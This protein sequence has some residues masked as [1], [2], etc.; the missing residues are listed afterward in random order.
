[1]HIWHAFPGLVR[2][3]FPQTKC[4]P[5]FRRQKCTLI[6]KYLSASCTFFFPQRVLLFFQK[7]II[8]LMFQSLLLTITY[9][10]TSMYH[11]KFS[12]NL[13]DHILPYVQKAKK[14]NR[15]LWLLRMPL[16]DVWFSAINGLYIWFCPW[17]RYIILGPASLVLCLVISS[18]C[19]VF[20]C[21]F[22]G[23]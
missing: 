21:K 12:W 9:L 4:L 6:G 14:M 3:I 1:M 11:A 23:I 22:H 13:P 5:S 17:L 8:I 15:F 19:P 2:N 20:S 10:V 18:S 16:R 7:R